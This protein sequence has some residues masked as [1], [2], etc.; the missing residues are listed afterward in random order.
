MHGLHPLYGPKKDPGDWRP[1]GD[2]RAL[3][4]AT[5]PDR[6][7]IPHIHDFSCFLEGKS[8]F[9]KV[10]LVRAYY[11]IPMAEEDIPKTAITTTFGLFEFI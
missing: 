10:D 11:Q 6:Y 2:Y 7:P 8:I 5:V 3:N 1:C 4:A 9:S